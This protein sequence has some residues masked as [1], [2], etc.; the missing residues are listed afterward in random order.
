MKRVLPRAEFRDW[1]GR[2]LPDL[3]AG[4]PP[5]LF[6]PATVSD[7]SDGKIAHLD[8]FNLT[9]AWCWRALPDA[10]PPPLAPPA[11]DPAAPPPDAR[12]PPPP[13]ASPA[14]PL[15]ATFPFLPPAPPPSSSPPPPP[16]P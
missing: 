2:F 7:R 11:H 10:L 12:P 16:P 13:G 15:P 8:G 5:S 9:R 4:E 6:T 3:A 14:P 1:F